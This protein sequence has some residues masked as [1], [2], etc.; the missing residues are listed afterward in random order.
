V[1]VSIVPN[2]VNKLVFQPVVE[3][4]VRACKF[5]VQV[6][7]NTWGPPTRNFQTEYELACQLK[8]DPASQMEDVAVFLKAADGLQV[9]PGIR[10]LKS[11]V[12]SQH[13]CVAYE[14]ASLDEYKQQLQAQLSTW[15]RAVEA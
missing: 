11:S 3:T 1:P 12:Q 7:H 9:E 2:M 6:L 5:F 10:Q 15:L 4:N 13:D 14:F 8:T